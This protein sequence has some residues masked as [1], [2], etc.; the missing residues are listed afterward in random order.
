MTN[1]LKKQTKTMHKFPHWNRLVCVGF[2]LVWLMNQVQDNWS[3]WCMVQLVDIGQRLMLMS[4]DS[5]CFYKKLALSLCSC[6]LAQP[7]CKL[8]VF[9][10]III[11]N[12]YDTIHVIFYCCFEIYY[13]NES[14]ANS[15][16]DLAYFPIQLDRSCTR[17][18]ENSFPRVHSKEGRRV[19][20]G[21]MPDT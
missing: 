3:F 7:I 10:A 12:V 21:W 1:N 19:M 18:T 13:L 9:T 20:N 6:E 5:I 15:L 16:W 4:E 2:M 17:M 14:L 8:A 11:N